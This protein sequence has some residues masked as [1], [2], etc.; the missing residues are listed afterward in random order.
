ML[1]GIAHA[2][3]LADQPAPFLIRDQNPFI[4]I[5][6]LPP[7]DAAELTPSRQ[8]T[9]QILFD[10]ANNSKLADGAN[11]SISLD[12]ETYRL[13]FS[14][15]HGL[16]DRVEAGIEVPLVF[17]RS[18]VLDDF[19]E[20]WH[21]LLGLDNGERDKTPS[22]ALD[23]S[24]R[25]QGQESIA[26]RSG[27]QGLGDVRVFAATTLYQADDRSREVSLH[28]SLKLPTGDSA[29]LLGSG[30]TDLALSVNAVERSLGSYR[31]TAYGRFGL[32]ASSDSDVLTAQQRHFVVFGGLGLNWHAGGP[33]DLKAQLDGH[34]SFYQSELPQLD[35][36]SVQLTLG[37]TIYFGRATALDLAVGEN[38][39]TDTI[40]DLLIQ[41]AVTHRN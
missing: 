28:G 40:P 1:G 25:F 9:I 4:Q 8:S 5:Y 17:H 37:G 26:I 10:L 14:V 39:F 20:G 12:G 22:N 38:L 18:G 7:H 30:S 24:H 23:Y 3:T 36:D 35:S 29:R 33:V 34:S 16:S 13:A 31:I 19:I 27:Q 41:I 11:E 6:G 32:L 15:R 21:D 2:N